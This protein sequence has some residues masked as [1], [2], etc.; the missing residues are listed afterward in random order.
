MRDL[1]GGNGPYVVHTIKRNVSVSLRI[2]FLLIN[3]LASLA[4][5]TTNYITLNA[6]L[7][8]ISVA[9]ALSGEN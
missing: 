7:G 2:D 4:H 1:S 9:N 6:V 8:R 5:F 3:A